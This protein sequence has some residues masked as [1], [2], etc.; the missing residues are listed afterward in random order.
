[1]NNPTNEVT[2]PDETKFHNV[3]N[4]TPEQKALAA[5]ASELHQDA[6]KHAQKA[7]LY[8]CQCGHLLNQVREKCQH[9]EWM[10]FLEAAGIIHE[11]ARRYMGVA[12]AYD[13]GSQLLL[14]GKSLADLYRALGFIKPAA[15][16]GNRLGGEELARRREEQQSTFH[17]VFLEDAFK[18][19]AR[20]TKTTGHV[21]PFESLDSATLGQTR[22]QLVSALALVDAALA[23]N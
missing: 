19:V 7:I 22:E 6:T 10:P 8:A 4:L 11:T 9:G 21:N 1:M 16:G 3:W 20:Y 14:E 17:F 13:P 2:T 12:Q 5:K 18:E 23:A 15:G